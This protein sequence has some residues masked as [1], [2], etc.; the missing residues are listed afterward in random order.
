MKR[1]V[2]DYEVIK[3]ALNKIPPGKRGDTHGRLSRKLDEIEGDIKELYRKRET[4][5]KT[6][7]L[8]S[9]PSTPEEALKSVKLAKEWRDKNA[10]FKFIG[11]YKYLRVIKDLESIIDGGIEDQDVDNIK[12]VVGA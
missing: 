2:I 8:V 9:K 1:D 3:L 10:L 11:R 5:T 12:K 4:L 7:E 6:R